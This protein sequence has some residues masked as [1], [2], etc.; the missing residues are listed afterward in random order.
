MVAVVWPAAPVKNIPD[1]SA[2]IRT[3][4]A[5]EV[6]VSPLLLTP[7]VQLPV[8]A[9]LPPGSAPHTPL[10]QFPGLFVFPG[11]FGYN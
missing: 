3:F 6:M 8:V 10:L 7:T 4:Q 1:L 2:L 5:R 11:R 9:W